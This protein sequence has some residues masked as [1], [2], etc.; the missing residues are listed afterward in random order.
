[1][2][3]RTLLAVLAAFAAA[4]LPAASGEAQRRAAASRVDWTATAVRTPE[5]GFRMGNPNA[6]VKL[7]EY[8]SLTCSH[9]ANF[10][11]QG[12]SRLFGTYV[13]SGD[14]S[15]EYRNYVRD[16]YDL[17]AAMVARCASPR[18][19]FDISHAL[20][21]SQAT[22]T[23]RIN[24]LTEAQRSELRALTPLQ[25]TARVARLLQL[26]TLAGRYGINAARLNACLSD[27]AALDQ[28]IEVRRAAEA[29]GVEGTPTFFLNGRLLQPNQWASIEPLLRAR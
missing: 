3:R 16:A 4:A 10:A 26:D 21:A 5:G 29:L 23:G 13:R 6:R 17:A 11:A 7:V 27:Q 14:V 8:V 28:V 9:C 24:G 15:V 19:Y 2:K 1:M 25:G 18:R 20:L 22:W 12:H